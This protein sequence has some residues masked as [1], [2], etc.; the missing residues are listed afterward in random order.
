MTCVSENGFGDN[1]LA[2]CKKSTYP[3]QTFIHTAKEC[4]EYLDSAFD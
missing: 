3:K 4:P 1:A 2:I